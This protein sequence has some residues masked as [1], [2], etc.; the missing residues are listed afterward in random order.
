MNAY[1]QLINRM[2]GDSLN[3]F[4]GDGGP[5]INS[6]MDFP[7][8]VAADSVGN[9]FIADANNNRIRMIEKSTGFIKTIAGGGTNI[10]GNGDTATLVDLESPNVVIVDRIG[11][12]YF[13][14]INRCVIRKIDKA[15]GLVDIIAGTFGSPGFF[16]DGGQALA[17]EIKYPSGLCVDDL[18]NFLYISDGSNYRIRKIDLSTG[19]I[20]TVAGVG[21][22][23]LNGDGGLA[24]NAMISSP[25][26]ITI[27]SAGNIYFGDGNSR[28]RRIDINTGIITTFAGT[29]TGYSGDGSSA[30]S[31][32][33]SEAAAISFDKESANLYFADWGNSVIRKIEMSSG[34]IQTIAGNQNASW[35]GNGGPALLAGLSWPNGVCV[36]ST[37]DIIIADTYQ[38]HVRKILGDQT[39]YY[40]HFPDSNAVWNF[41]N[42]RF[43][44]GG[45]YDYYYS[46]TMPGDTL[47]NSKDYHK[48]SVF[49]ATPNGVGT[50]AAGL[51]GYQGSV[52]EDTTLRMVFF[53]PPSGSVEE[54][55]YDF[56]MQVGDTMRG[57]LTKFVP[58]GYR[59]YVQ[60]IDSIMVG[61]SYRKRWH[62]NSSYS[63]DLI[64]G[65]GT[66][67]GLVMQSPGE[68][69]DGHFWYLDCFQQNGQAMYPDTI[70]NCQQITAINSIN[71]FFGVSIFPNPA[72]QLLNVELS[73]EAWL[74]MASLPRQMQNSDSREIKIFNLLGNEVLR[75]SYISP[76]TSIDISKLSAGVYILQTQNSRVRFVKE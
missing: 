48:L 34:I 45:P 20:S 35:I 69:G 65:I 39:G 59:D 67:Y 19:I 29:V 16:G 74:A 68:Q 14:E 43:C 44:T 72:G 8:S 76:R 73:R 33:L 60:S 66:T 21:I 63:I 53:I 10:P 3:G 5:A 36:T 41:H 40:Y 23:G 32:A 1:P 12:V 28:I 38:N 37:H 4:S 55:L 17:A 46:V 9:I 70:N 22:A 15:T 30:F 24:V 18:R 2:A 7:N 61:N 47:I 75:T 6:L 64:E 13:S 27:D 42:N 52:R 49:Y 58:M 26:G 11:N 56:N 51:V 25:A 31:A 50:C 54:L 71:K 57:Y 62:V